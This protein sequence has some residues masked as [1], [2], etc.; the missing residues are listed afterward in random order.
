MGPAVESETHFPTS[1]F[2]H[3]AGKTA[4]ANEGGFSCSALF[5]EASCTQCFHKGI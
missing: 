4:D 2:T 3:C 1:S 5:F